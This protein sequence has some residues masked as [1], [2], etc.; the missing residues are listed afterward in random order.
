MNARPQTS[1]PLPSPST[2]ST[3]RGALVLA[4]RSPSTSHFH[5]RA[6]QKSVGRLS[7]PPSPS[8]HLPLPPPRSSKERGAFVLTHRP[9]HPPPTPTPTLLK[10]ARGARERG[11]VVNK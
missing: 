10:R 4:R 2:L 3:K 9:L 11:L 7:S 1:S 6:L 8:T 5:L